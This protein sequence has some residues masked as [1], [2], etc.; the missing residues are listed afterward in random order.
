M[1][2][3]LKQA[4]TI[5]EERKKQYGDFKKNLGNI[6]EIV[7]SY[8]EHGYGTYKKEKAFFIALKMARLENIAKELGVNSVNSALKQTDSFLDL[9]GYALLIANCGEFCFFRIYN[10]I[11]STLRVELKTI[12][13]AILKG[14]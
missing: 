3:V 6:K 5:L 7:N 12:V 13:N 9:I 11:D 14:E 10:G 8:E 2:E 4:N 1:Q